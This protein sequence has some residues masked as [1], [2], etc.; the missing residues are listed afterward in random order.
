VHGI[1]AMQGLPGAGWVFP[2]L[3]TYASNSSTINATA[4]QDAEF[5][6]D[7]ATISEFEAEEEF[8]N[9]SGDIAENQ[10]VELHVTVAG[11]VILLGV[12]AVR[13]AA[14]KSWLFAYGYPWATA[15]LVSGTVASIATASIIM[16]LLLQVENAY[17]I[18]LLTAESFA[19]I[20]SFRRAKQEGLPHF[21]LHKMPHVL[22]WLNL[23]G[24]LR[25]RGTRRDVDLVAQTLFILTMVL[26]VAMLLADVSGVGGGSGGGGSGSGNGQG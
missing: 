22:M 5:E 21:R 23:R 20:T 11:R 6:G 24:L 19:A 2:G 3:E 16:V 13:C 14:V 8:V 9:D 7:A 26:V 15:C 17:G 1:A 4:L 12:G 25:K 10:E 18:R